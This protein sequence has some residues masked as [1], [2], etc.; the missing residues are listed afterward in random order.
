MSIAVCSSRTFVL[1]DRLPSSDSAE[2]QRNRILTALELRKGQLF[3][4]LNDLPFHLTRTPPSVLK[5]TQPVS[6]T[7]VLGG[8]LKTSSDAGVIRC[9]ARRYV[10]A[11]M[12]IL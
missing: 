2:A 9:H 7:A 6:M 3:A 5:D 11:L 4:E 12:R 8:A 1:I 10:S